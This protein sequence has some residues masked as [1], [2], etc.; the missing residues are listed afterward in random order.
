MIS[1]QTLPHPYRP[2]PHREPRKA[3]R[4]RR[5]EAGRLERVKQIVLRFQRS[6]Y[7]AEETRDLVAQLDQVLRS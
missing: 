5:T 4:R 7:L 1:R 6:G 3:R 2:E